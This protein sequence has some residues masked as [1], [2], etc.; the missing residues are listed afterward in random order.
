MTRSRRPPPHQCLAPASRQ[1]TLCSHVCCHS[2]ACRQRPGSGQHP[3]AWSRGRGQTA[4]LGV[5]THGH[6]GVDSL[7]NEAPSVSH[8]RRRW[9]RT[10]QSPATMVTRSRPAARHVVV[11]IAN[12]AGKKRSAPTACDVR[13][14]RTSGLTMATRRAASARVARAGLAMVQDGCPT[15]ISTAA[16]LSHHIREG[17]S[18]WTSS[19]TLPDSLLHVRQTSPRCCRRTYQK[20]PSRER[21]QRGR[22]SFEAC[23]LPASNDSPPCV[24][25]VRTKAKPWQ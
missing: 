8:A 23:H 16:R 24:S 12:S 25:V 21:I 9:S 15:A 17:Q 20:L 18:H 14:H 7:R 3:L 1:R 13:P 6:R 10:L 2:I 22:C 19:H 11:M 5:W 4:W